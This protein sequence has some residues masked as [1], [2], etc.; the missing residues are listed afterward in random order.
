[1]YAVFFIEIRLQ[2]VILHL[3]RIPVKLFGTKYKYFSKE[4]DHRNTFLLLKTYTVN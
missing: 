2:R 4:T 1:M 3:Q